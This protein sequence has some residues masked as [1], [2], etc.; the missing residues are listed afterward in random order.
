MTKKST[1]VLVI[2]GGI[3]GIQ[4]ALDLADAGISV[5]LVERTPSIGGR[6]AQ[7]DKTFPTNDCSM[8]ILSPKL[9]EVG[10][11]PNIKLLTNSE[12][13]GVEGEAGEFKVSIKKHPR[14]IIED[15]CTGCGDCVKVC[16]VALPND[17]DFGLST[18]K[19]AYIPFPQAVPLKYTIS[20]RG[21]SP[22]RAA[23]PAGI[24]GHGYIAL[25][26]EGKYQEALELVRQKTMFPGVLG[27]ICH[28]PCESA[29]NRSEL[30]EPLAICELKRF[31]ADYELE[32]GTFVPPQIVDTRD[33][34]IAIVGAGP[35]G[36]TAAS[37]L[38]RMGYKVTV[39]EA[40]P[41]PGGML[42]VGIP[43]YRLP[44]EVLTRELDTILGLGIDLKLNTRIGQD[45]TLDDLFK[46]GYKAVFLATGA[47]TSLKLKIE[48]EKLEG[49]YHGVEFLRDVSLGKK[50]KLG[51]KVVVIGGGNVAIDSVRTAKRLGADAFIIYRRSREEMP[52]Y[53]WEITEAEEEGIDIHYL[54]TPT[55]I[56]GKNDKVAEIECIKMELG[57][58]DDSGRR[59]PIPIKGSEFTLEVDT[60]I[61]AIGQLPDIEF[62]SNT[63]DLNFTKWNTLE[64]DPDTLMTSV[65]GVFAGGD[66]VLGPASAVDAIA[67]GNRAAAAIDRY[68]QG[69]KPEMDETEDRSIVAFE[70]LELT[71]DQKKRM[72]RANPTALNPSK[73]AQ[74]FQEVISN[75][76]SE[77]QAREEAQR[78]LNCGICSEC[79]EC[80][81]ACAELQAVDHAMQE[82][83]V[84]LEIGSI[85]VATGFDQVDPALKTEYGW[86]R[87][88]NVI[89][90]LEFERMMNA[91]GPFSGRIQRLS[92]GKPPQRIAFIQCVGSR[93]DKV[94]N[95]YCST[96]CCMYSTKEAVVA[97][98][99][100][101]NAEISI[102]YMDMRAMGKEFDDY[103]DRAKSEYG[104]KYI[105]SRVAEISETS[106]HNPIIHYVTEDLDYLEQE[107]D[108]VVLAMG[109]YPSN[110]DIE[111]KLSKILGVER[112]NYNFYKTNPL[113]PL[114]TSKNGIYVCGTLSGPK[115]I[116]ESV[117]QASGAAAKAEGVIAA[118]Q[119]GKI[120]RVELAP[121]HPE[122]LSVLDEE[123]RVGVFVCHCGINIA[124]VVDVEAV[125]KYAKT[126]PGVVYAECNIYTCSQDT[127]E[128]I[129]SQI[130]EHK[131]NRVVVAACTPRTHEPLFRNTVRECGLNP[132]LFEMVNI[133]DQCS[134]VHMHEP[135]ESTAKAKDL[136][137]MGVAKA[138]LLTPLE[139]PLI[140]INP[141][142]LVIGGG[143]AGMTAALELAKQDFKVHLVEKEP[144]LGGNFRK[145]FSLPDGTDPRE[146]TFEIIEKV[147]KNDKI[148]IYTE[149]ELNNISGYIGNFE[150]QLL[151]QS[152]PTESSE[153]EIKH[154]IIIVA[155]GAEEYKPTEY[156]YGKSDR[157]I[158]QFELERLLTK[159][160]G[161]NK[162][163]KITKLTAL[164]QRLESLKNIVMIQCIGAR[165][166]LHP[167]CSKVCC[168]QALKNALL[169]KSQYPKVN[170]YILYKDIRTYGLYEDLYKACSQKGVQFIRYDDDNLPQVRKGTNTLKV[171]LND[172]VLQ[173]K[174]ELDPELVI[175]SAGVVPNPDNDKL[176]KML[177]VPLSKDGFFLEAHMK[178]R[179]LDFATDGIFLC[180]LAHSP[181]SIDEALSQ[182]AGTA[183]R[184][185]TILA[186]SII[187]GEGIVSSID[188][189]LCN[190]CNICI[191]NCP[192]NA[193]ELDEETNK[194]KVTEI[195]CKGCGVCVATCPQQAV[196]IGFFDDEQ[197]LAQ[198]RALASGEE[199][200][201]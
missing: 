48:G 111:N 33:E 123:P 45:L 69:A 131:L 153:T 177:K 122:E 175:L 199:V 200:K 150:S 27:R 140:A 86:E 53:P 57:E 7:L 155:T 90:G 1:N 162:S 189:E 108:L 171:T 9:V 13:V 73:R 184:A 124:G 107:V 2:G 113:T 43:D 54:A 66:N 77:Q 172:P 20:K 105:R 71:E 88:P 11:H 190:G 145:I 21:D 147:N 151:H 64:V 137:R 52:A 89:S 156:L 197:I 60:V 188:E 84:E 72:P 51:K 146:K 58:P 6:M 198:V 74:N 30:D 168:V 138:R 154:G 126:L 29:C 59:R 97:Q 116:P 106:D 95:P 167:N 44:P 32:H 187:E 127:Q 19:A 83:L 125:E 12:V 47:H 4:A 158:T 163:E 101:P 183:A 22:C 92:D 191:I 109:M 68:I 179:P 3:A 91:S 141:E 96:V 164:A 142:A 65:K 130:T 42:A 178:L 143:L 166:E 119:G 24:N 76:F 93:D 87:Y 39:F 41:V 182:A 120:Q 28:H 181:K 35:A 129:K 128:L 103:V 132:Y 37:N 110:T 15:K 115:D 67:H 196:S 159:D 157:V 16:P 152:S 75:T 118:T 81:K 149:T 70:D 79:L 112:D 80:V 176:S 170:I 201:T 185:A 121:T 38:A 94:G 46:K 114:D 161:H 40:L 195:L 10:R 165:D 180:G 139:R 169:L 18:R 144:E 192:Y 31:L 49:V 194:A 5:Q 26:G 98:E 133:R 85:I 78:C 160:L 186:R 36:L 25:I 117:A 23:C 82:E 62:S 55:Q 148:K 100:S 174:L 135:L 63:K 61:P 50:P 56:L 136:V 102:F 99:H 134:W 104:L 8:C 173:D 17:F 14:Y 193:I 34:K